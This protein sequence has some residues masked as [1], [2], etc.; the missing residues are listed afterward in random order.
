MEDVPSWSLI[1]TADHVL[2]PAEQLFMSKR[3]KAHI[4]EGDA[5]HLSLISDPGAVA[6]VIIEAAG[7]TG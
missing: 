2:P 1:G 6:R 7:A 3:A 4:T 5:G